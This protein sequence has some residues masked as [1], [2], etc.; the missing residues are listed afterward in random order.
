MAGYVSRVKKD[1]AR[2]VEMGHIDAATGEAL[3]MDV[4]LREGNALSFGAV[5]G[6]MAALLFGA[7]ILLFVASNWEAIPRLVRVGLLFALI[8][9]G[10]LGGAALKLRDHAAFGEVLWLTGAAAFGG[11]I[12][13]IG[14]MYHLG[15]DEADA[16]LTW[17]FGTTLAAAALR[18]GPQ[19]VAA[20]GLA[21]AWLFMRSLQSWDGRDFPYLFPLLAAGLWMVSLWTRS[22]RSRHL[23]VLSLI[24][25]AALFATHR[26]AILVALLLSL[27]SAV[28]F[29]AAVYRPESTERIVRLARR[30]NA[31][32][33]IGFLV[34]M[35][36]A[37][38]DM[39]D[40]VLP[41]ALL[42]AATFAG[43]AAAL[44]LA[45]REGR[46]L[47]WIAYVGF[48]LELCFVYA[49]TIGSMLG[50][51]GFFFAAAIILGIIAFVIIR[52]ERRVN[53]RLAAGAAA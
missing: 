32:C 51:A 20:V 22:L 39:I 9:A 4:E 44:I 53:G 42:A 36:I 3:G 12:A 29:V 35:A 19:T 23:L 15:G 52:V 24:A 46:G 26:E 41:F 11:S 25:C 2:W 6:I 45:G 14:Q 8:L 16:V 47:R 18:S 13:A 1:I 49:V 31:Y 43:I 10:Y 33:L 28:L 17:C 38:I 7:A 48:G 30:F 5:L 50:T 27:V 37:Q 21:A 40:N 34:G